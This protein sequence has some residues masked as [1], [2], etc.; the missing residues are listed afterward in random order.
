M[1]QRN[2]Q[3]ELAKALAASVQYT[4]QEILKLTEQLQS[5]QSQI[6]EL[7]NSYAHP[8]ILSEEPIPGPQGEMGPQGP[9]GDKGEK[10]DKGDQG[11][12]GEQG[13]Q[14]AAGGMLT[15]FTPTWSPLFGY[16]TLPGYTKGSTVA[17]V[18]GDY[19]PKGMLS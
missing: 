19:L 14:G 3:L 1:S 10:G 17:S 11:I 18:F 4:K 8:T 15:N 2:D 5:L 7:D 6:E 13:I 9:K 12:Q 16:T